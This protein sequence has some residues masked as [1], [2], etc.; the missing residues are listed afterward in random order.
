MSL[1]SQLM[2]PE[3]FS[4]LDESTI[5]RLESAVSQVVVTDKNRGDLQKKVEE[6]HKSIPKP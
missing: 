1:L 6:L 5:A 2:R 3:E 4:K